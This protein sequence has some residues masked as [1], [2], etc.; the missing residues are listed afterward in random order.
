MRAGTN[1]LRGHNRFV[2]AARAPNP[3]PHCALGMK[4]FLS[5]TGSVSRRRDGFV[6]DESL[7]GLGRELSGLEIAPVSKASKSV[8]EERVKP[9]LTLSYPLGFVGFYDVSILL[10]SPQVI[11]DFPPVQLS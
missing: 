4:F 5:F 7:E 3:T 2:H 10:L 1:V 9:D 11:I 6:H 8:R